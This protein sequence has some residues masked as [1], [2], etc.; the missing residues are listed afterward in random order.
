MSTSFV[1]ATA[2]AVSTPSI[3]GGA[4]S[5]GRSLVSGVCG[6]WSVAIASIVPS[7][8]AAVSASTSAS[9]RSGGFILNT[10]SKVGARLVG[11]REVLR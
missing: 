7:A 4:S 8:S 9:E 11:E 2:S 10:G 3:P 6:A 1:I 5:N